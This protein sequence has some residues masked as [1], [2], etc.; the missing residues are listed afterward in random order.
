MAGRKQKIVLA[1]LLALLGLTIAWRILHPFRQERVASLT[2]N[3]KTVHK[4]RMTSGSP[5][6]LGESLPPSAEE[7]LPPQPRPEEPMPHTAEL[8]RDLFWSPPAAPPGGSETMQTPPPAPPDPMARVREELGRFRVFGAWEDSQGMA[9]FLERDKE[10][11]L[12]R[13]GDRID[14]RYR[15]EAIAGE[16]M[17]LMVEP[18]QEAIQ[19][20]LADFY[21]SAYGGLVEKES[22]GGP[23]AMEGEEVAGAPQE[24]PEP[25]PPEESPALREA[26]QRR[27]PAEP[28]G[29]ERSSER[30][31]LPGQSA[32]SPA[33]QAMGGQSR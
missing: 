1:A 33:F 20:D 17:T 10:I 5:P 15:V 16:R 6:P 2:H 8:R 14:G 3:G 32:W 18:E 30:Q 19:I 27:P 25:P 9:V 4:V 24:I 7:A 23:G 28:G 22:P 26:P 12:V 31:I 29:N 11:L 21:A 13:K